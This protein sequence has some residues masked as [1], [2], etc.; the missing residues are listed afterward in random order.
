MIRTLRGWP[1]SLLFAGVISLTAPVGAFA[2]GEV[3]VGVPKPPTPPA[4]RTIPT[5]ARAPV[6]TGISTTPPA[7]GPAGDSA[8]PVIV[9]NTTISLTDLFRQ[10]LPTTRLDVPP[11]PAR[12][13]VL[14]V[15]TPGNL[16]VL[17]KP[18]DPVRLPAPTSGAPSLAIPTDTMPVANRGGSGSAT[19]GTGTNAGSATTGSGGN[20]GSATDMA[21]RSTPGARRDAPTVSIPGTPPSPES[22]AAYTPNVSTPVER[23][24]DGR[25][26]DGNRHPVS[27]EASAADARDRA[28]RLADMPDHAADPTHL[29]GA[30][31]TSRTQAAGHADRNAAVDDL[32]TLRADNATRR[33]TMPSAP[34]QDWRPTWRDSILAAPGDQ[35]PSQPRV[36]PLGDGRVLTKYPDGTLVL[37]YPDGTTETTPANSDRRIT[38]RPDGSK[39]T[40]WPNGR[41]V[42]VTPDGNRFEYHP[43]GSLTIQKADGSSYRESADK[44]TRTSTAPNGDRVSTFPDDREEKYFKSSGVLEVRF[45]TGEGG[46]RINADGTRTELPSGSFP[47]HIIPVVSSAAPPS[48]VWAVWDAVKAAASYIPNPLAYVPDPEQAGAAALG[49]VKGVG[50]AFV[51]VGHAAGAIVV[52]GTANVLGADRRGY[53][54]DAM[55]DLDQLADGMVAI[56]DRPSLLYLAPAARFDRA[57]DRGDA[58]GAG[59]VYGETATNAVIVVDAA[60]NAARSAIGAVRGT[61]GAAAPAVTTTTADTA[62]AGVVASTDAASTAVSGVATAV[63]STSTVTRVAAAADATAAGTSRVAAAG[64]AA[65]ASAPRLAASADATA[66]SSGAPAIGGA[67][68]PARASAGAPPAPPPPPPSA[69]V[70]A[71]AAGGPAGAGINITARGLAHVLAR[72]VAGGAQTAGKS[73]FSGGVADVRALIEAARHTLPT[74]QANGRLQRIVDAGRPIGFDRA[75]GTTTSQYTV[76]T[77]VNGNLVTAFPGLP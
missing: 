58:F 37:R 49:A 77:E 75:T 36:F 16:L 54:G 26:V 12:D 70:V 34:T 47:G 13:A 40:V 60:A 14:V 53:F 63:E 74:L 29:L 66:A 11:P 20:A 48:S 4:E 73:I 52:G 25:F 62:A 72:H 9:P 23:R 28:V 2:Q 43:D 69:P 21:D 19:T 17:P 44:R 8:P 46:Y 15:P 55:R 45:K 38:V 18:G 1:S 57:I 71:S 50:D 76:I 61:P 41:R 64:E 6:L 33:A 51:G 67:T 10:A 32:R 5:G 39:T 24:D 7:D 22:P 31:V 3:P 65:S 59:Q 68:G 56:G 35:Q 30:D 27:G 42:E